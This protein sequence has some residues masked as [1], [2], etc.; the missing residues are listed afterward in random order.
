MRAWSMASHSVT[1]SV[2]PTNSGTVRKRYPSAAMAGLSRSRF[3][4]TCY[5]RAGAECIRAQFELDLAL[6]KRGVLALHDIGGDLVL[7]YVVVL[8]QVLEEPAHL[9]P[10]GAAEQIR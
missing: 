7:A 10:G 2:R 4:A 9:A 8:R 6:G 1:P 5:Q 3:A